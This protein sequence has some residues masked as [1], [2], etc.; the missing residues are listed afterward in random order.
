MTNPSP[1]SLNRT[2]DRQLI[3][4]WS[5]GIEQTVS[6]RELRNACQCAKC[7]E[8]KLENVDI[9]NGSLPVLSPAETMPLEIVEMKPVGNYAYNVHF[10]D[11]HSSGIFTFELLRKIG[12]L[13]R[14]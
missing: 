12:S 4:H 5:D 14:R 11:G 10:S 8:S 2:E 13:I 3:I 9:N 1:T 6:F 7:N